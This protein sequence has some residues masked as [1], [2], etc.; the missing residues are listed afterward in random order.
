MNRIILL[1]MVGSF[2]YF[3]SA[4]AFVVPSFY[5]LQRI[6][7][8]KG[9]IKSSI[10]EFRVIRPVEGKKQKPEVLWTGKLIYPPPKASAVWF[11]Q[12]I[13]LIPLY[14]EPEAK[15]LVQ[16]FQKSGFAVTKEEDLLL[17]SPEEMKKSDAAPFPFYKL[18]SNASISR[19]R[20]R[21]ALEYKNDE[22]G[23]R[24][25]VEKDSFYPLAI[26]TKCPE[27]MLSLAYGT[28]DNDI[29]S[30]DF[31]YR[32]GKLPFSTPQT[33]Y[34]SINDRKIA[35]LR[36]DKIVA[37]PSPKQIAKVQKQINSTNLEKSD[38]IVAALYKFILY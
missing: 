10:I 17:W 34:I 7:E 29:C 28:S 2:F 38:D 8:R 1:L 9:E 5:A 36:I 22:T 18:N 12:R 25:L 23:K 13:P 21:I 33:A 19:H 16:F 14:V 20:G 6:A 4:H 26:S 15:S 3:S 31:E 30:I 11:E 37:D 35:V 27:S 24:L 32:S